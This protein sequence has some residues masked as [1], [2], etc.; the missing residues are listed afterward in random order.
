MIT[1]HL[2]PED[3]NK[4]RFAYRPLLEIPL[5]YR[6][7]INPA[8]QSP[9]HR[10]VDEAFRTLHDVSLPYL[11]ALVTDHGYIPDFLTPTPSTERVE[12]EEDFDELLSTPEDVIRKGALTLIE[13]DGDSEMRRYFVAYPHEAARCLVE[14]MRTYW[15][16]TLAPYWS[17][18]MSTLESDVLYRARLLAVD[19]AGSLIDDLHSSV[20]FRHDQ[21]QIQPVCQHRHQDVGLT[22]SGNGIQLVPLIFRGCGRMFQVAPEWRPMLAYGVRGAG[23]WYQKPTP[24]YQS[25]ELAMGTGRARILRVL[26]MPT[27]TGEVAFKAGISAATASQHLTRLTKAG[28]VEPRRSGKRVF[29]HL[30]QRGIELL[31]LFDRTD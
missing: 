30:T 10:W 14:D 15:R 22:L 21:I 23:L 3:L 17:R 16:S 4:M 31:A 28:L 8:F 26:A 5:S 2:T 6:I 24:T 13:E 18:M 29:Y 19:G 7:L 25:L 1:I 9:Y 20:A 11:S 12:V 27:S